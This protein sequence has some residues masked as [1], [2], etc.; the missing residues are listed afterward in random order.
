MFAVP[1]FTAMIQ[2]NLRRSATQA[3]LELDT[4]TLAVVANEKYAF[5]TRFP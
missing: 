4:L 2:A 1:L 3:H 5:A